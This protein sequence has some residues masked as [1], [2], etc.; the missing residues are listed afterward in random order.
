MDEQV[1]LF[2]TRTVSYIK[3]VGKCVHLFFA[4]FLG[5][6]RIEIVQWTWVGEGG[7]HCCGG[8]HQFQLPYVH[9]NVHSALAH[10]AS[11]CTVK[12]CMIQYL[13]HALRS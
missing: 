13:P 9:S 12:Y 3:T 1:T 4:Q 10:T 8:R 5:V 6:A 7:M 11:V 2:R